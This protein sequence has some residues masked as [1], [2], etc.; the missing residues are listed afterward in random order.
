MKLSAVPAKPAADSD[1]QLI[2]E[3]FHALNQPLTALRCSLELSLHRPRAAEQDRDTL[4]MALDHAEQIARLS[5]G[6]REL[7]Q[8]DDPGDNC[9]VLPLQGYLREA[10]ADFQPVAEARG[11]AL[12]LSGHGACHVRLE[13]RRL[14]QALFCLLDSVLHASPTG[15]AVDI[16]VVERG[17]DS[18]IALA[19]AERDANLRDR[20]A[21]LELETP[22]NEPSQRLGWAIARRIVETAGGTVEGGA[23]PGCGRIELRLPLA[24]VPA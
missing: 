15:T 2:S 8:A 9:E 23:Q 20:S 11:I 7:L 16:D 22:I 13:P 19:W 24:S 1:P 12:A 14:R 18:V 4:R 21:V 10:V 6:I 5:T 17:S 3:L